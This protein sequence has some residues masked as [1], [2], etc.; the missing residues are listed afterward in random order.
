MP[1]R[2]RSLISGLRFFRLSAEEDGP[3]QPTHQ[4]FENLLRFRVTLRGFLRWSEDHAAAVGLTSAQHQLLVAI[5]GHP[6]PEPP[7]IRE[8]AEY[9]QLQSHSAVGLVDRAEAAGFVRRQQD[10]KDARVVRVHL[11]EKGDWLVTALASAHLAELHKLAS[12]L[13]NLLPRQTAEA[14]DR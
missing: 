9:L 5:K 6:G 10:S 14:G 7:A 12:A 4:D 13:N 8:L 2:A 11:T 3:I 1:V